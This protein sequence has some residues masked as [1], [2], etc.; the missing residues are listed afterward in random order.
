MLDL[1]A[2]K[3]PDGRGVCGHTI[4]M[5]GHSWF[6]R[7]FGAL[8]ALS[9]ALPSW[10]NFRAGKV[11]GKTG[12]AGRVSLIRATGLG[13]SSNLPN[14]SLSVIPSLTVPISPKIEVS[15]SPVLVV[16]VESVE[17]PLSQITEVAGVGRE[18]PGAGNGGNAANG[19]RRTSVSESERADDPKDRG[20]IIFDGAKKK[21]SFG[22]FMDGLMGKAQ[23]APK[24]PKKLSHPVR[25]LGLG[26]V[27]GGYSINGKPAK[28]IGFGS[29]KTAL[30]HPEEP[31]RTVKV[32]DAKQLTGPLSLRERNL[33]IKNT[34]RLSALGVVPK[35]VDA[36]WFKAGERYVGFV[37]E[38][39]VNG[40]DLSIMTPTKYKYVKRLFEILAENGVLIADL[41]IPVKLRANIKV[42]ETASSGGTR[43]WLVDRDA[44]FP[45]N[46]SKAK[47][48]AIYARALKSL[49]PT[50]AR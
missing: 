11:T 30:R 37:D 28:V 48:R 21:S 19:S 39:M 1:T 2:Q 29:F 13:A 3:A 47:L 27:T 5:A 26:S 4:G 43:A 50:K 14:V 6:A 32:F 7:A 40:S 31:A 41:D 24:T 17:L 44:S 33:D 46:I 10:A 12:G 8:F 9:L 20:R 35:I 22:R 36:G 42:G 16:P 23:A 25:T 18:I 34:N 45:K 15:E 49:E 38:E